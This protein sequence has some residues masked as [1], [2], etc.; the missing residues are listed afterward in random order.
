MRR[1]RGIISSATY[2]KVL[3][4]SK[5]SKDIADDRNLCNNDKTKVDELW[6]LHSEITDELTQEKEGFDSSYY[7]IFDKVL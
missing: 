1:V 2:D 4:F 3:Y 5:L 7:T 6:E